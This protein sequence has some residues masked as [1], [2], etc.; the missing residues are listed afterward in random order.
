MS[1]F[2]SAHKHHEPGCRQCGM[3]DEPMK[4]A[5]FKCPECGEI[6]EEIYYMDS[7]V[8][9]CPYCDDVVMDKYDGNTVSAKVPVRYPHR[10]PSFSF[11]KRFTK[12]LLNA[13]L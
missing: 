4:I 12:R 5:A 1:G 8:M 7:S 9:N 3:D 2:C 13:C 10:W 6:F 11:K